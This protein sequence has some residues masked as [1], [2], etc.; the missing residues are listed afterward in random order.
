M[1]RLVVT[2]PALGAQ[3]RTAAA[4]IVKNHANAVR[5]WVANANFAPAG[6]P[7]KIP[8]TAVESRVPG[9]GV[10][11]ISFRMTGQVY[12]DLA[13]D[14][15][16]RL[17]AIVAGGNRPYPLPGG[18]LYLSTTPPPN[19]FPVDPTAVVVGIPAGK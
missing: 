4:T 19:L 2:N 7:G 5:T 9:V 13:I 1:A 11:G 12:T 3:A 15:M 16:A 6:A 10:D 17:Q 18:V 8:V 14:Q